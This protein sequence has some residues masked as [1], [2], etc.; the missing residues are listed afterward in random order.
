LLEGEGEARGVA[1]L[2][3][4]LDCGKLDGQ[5][6]ASEMAHELGDDHLLSAQELKDVLSIACNHLHVCTN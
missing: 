3:Q 1:E 2:L 4:E 5:V 6:V